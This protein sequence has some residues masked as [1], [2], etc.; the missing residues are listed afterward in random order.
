MFTLVIILYST[1]VNRFYLYITA[2]KSESNK[3]YMWEESTLCKSSYL[4]WIFSFSLLLWK[5][6]TPPNNKIQNSNHKT[7]VSIATIHN[8]HINVH[9]TITTKIFDFNTLLHKMFGLQIIWKHEL[10]P[11]MNK[12]NLH[13][14]KKVKHG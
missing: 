14:E 12:Y 8:N 9:I 11:K 4:Y 13:Y 3:P 2:I 10:K 7:C 5:K 6:W 1:H